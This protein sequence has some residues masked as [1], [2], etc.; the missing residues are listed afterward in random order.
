M[1]LPKPK[2]IHHW[3]IDRDNVGTCIKCS[4]VRDFA[5]LMNRE[6]SKR[7]FRMVSNSQKS[8]AKRSSGFH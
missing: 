7:V 6:S 4:E 1:T 5:E 2:C 3:T 8:R